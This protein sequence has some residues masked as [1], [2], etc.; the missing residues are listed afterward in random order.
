[1]H[2]TLDRKACS[3]IDKGVS[4]KF[5]QMSIR[6]K[7]SGL[8]I[9]AVDKSRSIVVDHYIDSMLLATY[10]E[11]PTGVTIPYTKFL[12]AGMDR[13]TV[14]RAGSLLKLVWASD[15]ILL[16]K[17]VYLLDFAWSEVEYSLGCVLFSLQ[18]SGLCLIRRLCSSELRIHVEKTGVEIRGV[19][20]NH[21]VLRSNL[22]VPVS[23]ECA[24]TLLKYHLDR[25]PRYTYTA[26]NF[27][28]DRQGL[29][30]LSLEALG[31]ITTVTIATEATFLD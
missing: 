26:A 17:N 12:L 6:L 23:H 14:S 8:Y 1:M 5:E 7:D 2:I 28:I 18:Y 11:E 31:V 19:S 13:L 16:E 24:F 15:G 27:S 22:D 3:A 20:E 30:I 4:G 10:D 21:V 9:Q 29:V 25:L